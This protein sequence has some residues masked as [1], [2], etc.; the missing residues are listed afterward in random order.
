MGAAIPAA[1]ERPCGCSED[2][3]AGGLIANPPNCVLEV[4]HLVSTDLMGLMWAVF[5]GE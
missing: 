5:Y 1:G 3:R 2:G 4:L